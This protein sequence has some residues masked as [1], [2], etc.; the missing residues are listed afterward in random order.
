MYADDLVLVSHSAKS[1]QKALSILTKYCDDRM[2]SVNPKKT[3]LL[4]FQKKCRKST[5]DKYYFQINDDKI[6]I[7]NNYTYLGINFSANGSFRNC[8][9]NLKD[10]TRMYSCGELC[11]AMEGYVWHGGLCIAMENYVELWRAVYS[12]GGLCIAMEGYV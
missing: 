3:K 5:Y 8:K 4:I 1:L 7:V 11:I 2:L 12:Y 9:T 10:K 6:D